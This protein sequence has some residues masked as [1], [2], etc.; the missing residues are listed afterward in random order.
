METYAQTENFQENIELF[1]NTYL[2]L[3][4][5]SPSVVPPFLQSSSKKLFLH[6]IL[7]AF[8]S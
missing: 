4:I 3:L 2:P 8:L 6:T 1:P 7:N 5:L